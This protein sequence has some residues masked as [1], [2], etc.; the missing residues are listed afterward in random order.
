MYNFWKYF[1]TR[2]GQAVQNVKVK[3]KEKEGGGGEGGNSCPPTHPHFMSCYVRGF[4][5]V[6]TVVEFVGLFEIFSLVQ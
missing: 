4:I 6:F 1:S 2:R 3:K 5:R